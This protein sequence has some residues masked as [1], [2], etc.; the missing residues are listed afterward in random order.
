VPG[1]DTLFLEIGN[2]L[3]GRDTGGEEGEAAQMMYTYTNKYKNN[4]KRKCFVY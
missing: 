1:S 4:E 2:V 3:L